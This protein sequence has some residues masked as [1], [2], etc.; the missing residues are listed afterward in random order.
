MHIAVDY[1]AAYGMTVLLD[2]QLRRGSARVVNVASDTIRD[3]RRI[4][5]VGGAR[6]ATINL[7]QLHDLSRLNPSEG[8]VP[9][10]AYAR[11]KLLTV[12]AG[13]DLARSFISDGVTVNAVHP[14]IVATDIIHDLVPRPL[15]PFA[16]LIRRTML[17]PEQGATAALRLATDDAL[18]GVTGRYFVRDA[19]TPT[20]AVSHDRA[21]Q[22][23]LR[24]VTDRFFD[25]SDDGENS[26]P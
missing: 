3:T 7:D 23:K 20:P 2:R 12:T 26:R 25:I 10:E 1:L 19:E 22:Q 14:G 9:F 17:T 18:E 13:Y 21:V 6:P 15:R 24:T 8:F 4:K 11:A 16:G 5:L